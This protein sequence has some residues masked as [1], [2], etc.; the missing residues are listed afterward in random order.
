MTVCRRQRKI[1][2]LECLPAGLVT[3]RGIPTWGAVA[4]F[5]HVAV[6]AAAACPG[7]LRF[8]AI[9][10]WAPGTRILLASESSPC[11]LPAAPGRTGGAVHGLAAAPGIVRASV[12]SFRR[13]PAGPG[14]R[15][16]GRIPDD[17]VSVGRAGCRPHR[18]SLA[19]VRR[20]VAC[21][22]NPEFSA[23]GSDSGFPGPV[24]PQRRA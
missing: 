3:A 19:A 17:R 22:E 16:V 5:R 23:P 2:G 14:R 18:R 13:I 7:V 21:A 6:P 20:P 9:R 10:T 1:S 11:W 4:G 24:R 12:G 15:A 8:A